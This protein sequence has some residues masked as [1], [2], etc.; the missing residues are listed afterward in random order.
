MLDKQDV[1]R[2]QLFADLPFLLALKHLEELRP[3]EAQREGARHMCPL[4]G[5]QNHGR[6]R[7]R[8]LPKDEAPSPLGPQSRLGGAA[9]GRAGKED[10]G[11][12][13]EA[14]ER[15]Q[16]ARGLRRGHGCM[17]GADIWVFQKALPTNG[18]K[19]NWK[20]TKENWLQGPGGDGGAGPTGKGGG[21]K[22]LELELGS[23]LPTA[24]PSY[25][26]TYL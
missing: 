20:K 9:L 25:F 5:Q 22:A 26:V 17:L 23:F 14:G 10:G 15:G 18:T 2:S 1:A 24:G 12:S 13:R 4:S 8:P 19:R 7:Q 6:E 21:R 11:G 16:P 3:P